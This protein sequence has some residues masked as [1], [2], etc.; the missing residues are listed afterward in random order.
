MLP[1][2]VNFVKFRTENPR[3][4]DYVTETFHTD[5]SLKDNMNLILC[6]TCEGVGTYEVDEDYRNRAPVTHVCKRCNGTG[7]LYHRMFALTIASDFDR[8]KVY[9]ATDKIIGIIRNL[10]K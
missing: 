2:L 7:R 10:E 1:I 8:N 9:E 5:C 4:R 6:N 3:N